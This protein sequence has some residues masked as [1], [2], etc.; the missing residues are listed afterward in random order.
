MA[1][2]KFRIEIPIG[3][4]GSG[5]GAKGKKDDSMDELNKN[6][7]KLDKT[8]YGT[9]DWI[10]MLSSILGDVYKLLQ[11]IF[12][13]LSV[14]FM[15]IFLPLLPVI[16]DVASALAEL[17]KGLSKLFKGEISIW[18]FI[19]Q[20]VGP[21]LW[22]AIKGL[23]KLIDTLFFGMFSALAETIKVMWTDYIW[24][25]LKWIGEKFAEL[26]E[27]LWE[28][29][30]IGWEF[31]KGIGMWLWENIIYPAWNFLVNVGQ[32]IWE[33]ILKPAWEFLSEVGSWIWDQILKPAFEWLSDV[34]SKIWD[35]LKGPFKWVADKIKSVTSWFSFGGGDSEDVNDA[36]ITPQG[37]VIKTAPQ[38]YIFATKNP[39]MGGEVNIN[40]NN[41]VVR[42]DQDI[43]EIANE[44]SKV[45]RR[46]LGGRISAG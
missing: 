28:M 15:I 1:D 34:G 45:M 22:D 13:L 19:V 36:V 4:E 12:K 11:P 6:V 16:K 17:I 44:V 30:L 2:D 24:P 25:A 20:H 18:E 46:Q 14:M 8:M 32:W 26:G 10:E 41:P 42:K 37:Q 29:I 9:L 38:D 3:T 27:W 33:Q 40:I 39:K 43:K 21:A 7:K 5:A 31:M 23:F 35:I